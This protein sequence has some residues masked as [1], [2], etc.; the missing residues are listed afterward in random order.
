MV[1]I[2][3]RTEKKKMKNTKNKFVDVIIRLRKRNVW[4]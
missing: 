4:K 1:T 2:Q 3:P